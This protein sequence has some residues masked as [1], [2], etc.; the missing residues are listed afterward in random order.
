MGSILFLI[1][2]YNLED[3]ISSAVLEFANDSCFVLLST[4]LT[5]FVNGQVAGI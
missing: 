1:F 3:G 5:L 2:I 4:R